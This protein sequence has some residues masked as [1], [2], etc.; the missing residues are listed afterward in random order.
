MELSTYKKILVVEDDD[1]SYHLIKEI[2]RSFKINLHL[3]ANSKEALEY[4]KTNPDTSLILMD[5]K[6]PEVDGYI[7]S[8][9]I[10]EINPDI[11]IIAQTAFA[12]SGDREKA[13]EAGCCEYITKPLNSKKLQELV[14]GY[15]SD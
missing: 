3:A 8:K 5:I 14:R 10:K 13:M 12:M 15:L 9:M 11:P 6:L 1:S 7:T 2:L 4:V